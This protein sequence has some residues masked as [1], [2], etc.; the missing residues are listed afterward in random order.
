VVEARPEDCP[1]LL[2]ASALTA[3]YATRFAPLRD[4]KGT[5]Y[6]AQFVIHYRFVRP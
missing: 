1:S 6:R 4:E 2:R 3:A 5:A